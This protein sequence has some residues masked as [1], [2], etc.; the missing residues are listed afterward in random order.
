MERNIERIAIIGAMDE[1][2]VA[3]RDGLTEL[4]EHP[5]PFTDLP[6]FTGKLDGVEVVIARCGIG[7]VN[8]AL[9]TQYLID[10]FSLKAIINSG[11]AG[12]ISPEVKIGQLV[13]GHSS[14]Q[15]DFD[16][17]HFDYPQGTIP[18]LETSIFKGDPNLVELAFEAG[19]NKVGAENIH[20]GLIVSGD[21][22][23]SS[24]EQKQS[25][26]AA[27]PTATCVEMEG[28]AIAHVAWLNQ[29]PHVIV[30]AIS[31]QADNTA[32]DDFDAYLLEVIPTLNGVIR[33][34]VRSAHQNAN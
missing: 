6:V 10:Q 3:L 9:A 8:A 24:V 5:T 7:K 15:H 34:L 4:E 12:G 18:R 17:S 32:P 21:Q 16:V 20:R 28:A 26:L 22:F 13:I 30:R 2:V 29:I 14:L 11:V 25:I 23:V 1:E 33:A 31:D 27:F 19:E